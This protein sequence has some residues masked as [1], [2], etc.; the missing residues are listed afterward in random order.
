MTFVCLCPEAQGNTPRRKPICRPLPGRSP[1]SPGS[2][3]SI[4]GSLQALSRG[5]RKRSQIGQFSREFRPVVSLEA[6]CDAGEL[7][8]WGRWKREA[9]AEPLARVR[10]ETSPWAVA[11]TLQASDI[12][13]TRLVWKKEWCGQTV[14]LPLAVLFPGSPGSWDH[15]CRGE[16]KRAWLPPSLLGCT[17]C[18][19][20]IHLGSD[21]CS[22]GTPETGTLADCI[23][24][25]RSLNAS[26]SEATQSFSAKWA[27][28]LPPKPEGPWLPTS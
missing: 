13:R 14:V 20:K 28:Q 3:T 18:E 1:P 16:V 8:Q 11:E 17:H 2:Q 19:S 4:P 5:P 22:Q 15:L 25:F 12:E 21:L 27:R 24:I 9:S 23:C 10:L 26:L 7:E 6:F